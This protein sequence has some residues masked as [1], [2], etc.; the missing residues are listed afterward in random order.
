VKLQKGDKLS[1]QSGTGGMFKVSSKFS[2]FGINLLRRNDVSQVNVWLVFCQ[3]ASLQLLCLHLLCLQLFICLQQYH[4]DTSPY[5]STQWS[6]ICTPPFVNTPNITK[7]FK[8]GSLTLL[9][10]W[11]LYFALKCIYIKRII[12]HFVSHSFIT[13]GSCPILWV[14]VLF[15]TQSVTLCVAN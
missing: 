1:L 6:R 12:Y 15:Y 10:G 14:R 5:S 7:F 4:M 13:H 11:P 2:Y 3:R 8:K 9:V